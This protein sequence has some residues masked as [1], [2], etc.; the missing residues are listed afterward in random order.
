MKFNEWY[1][2][3]ENTSRYSVE[4]N[5]KTK[6]KDVL[7]GF[8]KISLAYISAA[9]KRSGYHVKRI[10]EQEPYRVIV[11]SR[12]WDDGEWVGMVH[13]NP[14]VQGGCFVISKGFYN[15]QKKTVLVQ[16]SNKCVQD[17]PADISK[18]LKSMM[19]ELKNKK[20]N[21][22]EKLNPVKLKRGPK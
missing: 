17:N 13:Y 4:V 14:N 19:D 3:K 22:K 2:L 8:A 9:L 11:S 1:L 10:L 20:N 16:S 7:N 18:E 21:H 12:N 5:Y 15:K 6:A